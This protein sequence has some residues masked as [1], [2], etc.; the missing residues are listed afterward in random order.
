MNPS[1]FKAYD[2]RGL[3][4]D[5]INEDVATRFG[6]A[7]AVFLR[8]ETGKKR[9]SV[10]VGQDNRTHSPQ[11]WSALV[12]GL[13]SA[14]AD[15]VD[16]GLASTPFFYYAASA[17]KLD[18]GINV[19]A[20]HNP[21]EYNGFKCV[22]KKAEPIGA[23]TGLREIQ[24]LFEKIGAHITKK[25][26]LDEYIQ[27]NLKLAPPGDWSL[28]KVAIDTGNGVSVLMLKK[29][30]AKTGLKAVPLY[31]QLDGTFPNH[32]PNPLVEKNIAALKK[33]VVEK[34]YSCGIALDADGDRCIF[35]NE[36][37]ET[38]SSDLITA[39]VASLLLKNRPGEKIC[40]D[41]TS[42]RTTR[43]VILEH[44]GVPVISRVGHSFIKAMMRDE[45]ILFAGERSGHFYFRF[46]ALG[47]FEA[48]LLVI[49]ILL[50]L[51]A[52]TN[53]PLS[54]IIAPF[55]RY[56]STGEINFTVSDKVGAI[57]KI[58]SL[59]EDAKTVLH[60]DGITIEYD[61]WW[62]NVRPSNTEPLLRL[63]LEA[64]S[65]GLRDAKL[66]EITAIIQKNQEL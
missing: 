57:Q 16:I 32:M 14:G 4:P 47:Y 66:K 36:K 31:F 64:T 35:I 10:A 1:I 7:F 56:A 23:E 65:A 43:E 27:K 46:A 15:V 48:P 8:R 52:K 20:S 3:V 29:L 54:E 30:I 24:K 63:N 11:L 12:A 18:G 17:L 34:K 22:R 42:S 45:N 40:Y 60:L 39:L 50:N 9:V 33:T 49:I 53:R 55:Q 38:I 28:L 21:P 13:T 62:C 26:M 51:L 37:G 6:Q 19:T 2:V 58:E 41:A 5:E 25:D 59:H 44:G 61:D